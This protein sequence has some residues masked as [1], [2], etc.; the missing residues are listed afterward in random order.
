ML[1]RFF[2]SPFSKVLLIVVIAVQL[3]ACGDAGD[4][5][6]VT[7]SAGPG[8][9]DVVLTGSVGDGPVTG[10]TVE[11]WSSGGRLIKTIQSDNTA[12]FSSRIR[13]WRSSYP[14]L[15]KVRGGI[16]LVTGNAPDF[17]M[18]SV[19]LDR[20]AQ[21]VNIN[22]FS[23]LIVKIAQ[24]LPGGINA[25]N[26]QVATGTVIDKLGFGLDLNLIADPI[27]SPVTDTNIANLMKSSEAMGE[28]IRR[29]RDLI[30][31]TG[32]ET[33]GD[34]VLAAIAA[35]LQD[36]RLDGEGAVGT[37]PGITVMTRV[38][39]GQV[40]VEALS[41]NLK[42]GGVVATGVIDESIKI[43]RP[44]ISASQLTAGVHVTQGLLDQ[45]RVSLAAAQV[46]DPGFEVVDLAATVSSL[47][48]GDLPAKVAT[49]LP[50]DSARALDN[51]V[52]LSATAT[53]AE[54]SAVN[55]VVQAGGGS[56]IVDPGTNTPGA[57]DPGTTST[58][59]T[60]PDTTSPGTTDPGTSDTVNGN[61]ALGRP[62][63]VSSVEYAG[64]EGKHAVDGDVS[65]RWSSNYSDPEWIYVDLGATYT[66]ERVVLNWEAYARSFDIQVSA[67]ARNWSTVFSETSGNDGIID[68]SIT[69]SSARY[70]RLLGLQRGTQYGYSLWEIGIYGGSSG[71][72][73]SDETSG[74]GTTGGDT[75]STGTSGSSTASG[76]AT[77][78]D[79]TAP[80]YSVGGFTLNW[81]AP[82]TRADGAPLSL[83]DIEGFRIYYGTSAGN[84]P[85]TVDINDGSAQAATVNDIPTGTYHV[86]MTTYDTSG[87]ES[88]YSAEI[89]KDAR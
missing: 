55:K 69:P 7:D 1:K 59:V 38:V 11:V 44:G 75:S 83:A 4:S 32:M 14:L 50:A 52:Q 22:P 84:Y 24:S 49:V 13:V 47:A 53:S 60:D 35:D 85:N 21:A 51:A 71:G 3:A 34:A 67:D 40:L 65:S 27:S 6:S 74:G 86:V 18:V 78:S 61:L 39:S 46:L 82:T 66:V 81:T 45:T 2:C 29:T 36:G 15:L 8:M 62:V 43:T 19:K 41:N 58:D 42:V 64:V 56:D 30:A 54:I 9:T 68:I 87:L 88:N 33:S 70:V 89:V 28:M 10:A 72:A 37:D 77:G 31:A 20:Y 17:E 5:A 73:T 80:Q 26:I 48:A 25:A 16:D 76:S 23:T 12:S 57:T 79:A 63:V